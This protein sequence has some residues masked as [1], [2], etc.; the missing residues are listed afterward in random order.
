MKFSPGGMRG[1]FN[2]LSNIFKKTVM[3]NRIEAEDVPVMLGG[4]ENLNLAT[5]VISGSDYSITLLALAREYNLTC[6]D[7]AYLELAIRTEAVVGTLD[8]ELK[9]ACIKAGLPTV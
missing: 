8:N 1:G 6:Y 9:E 2:D 3:R 7:A 5:D 4:I